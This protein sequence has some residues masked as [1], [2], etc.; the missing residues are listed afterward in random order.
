M[1]YQAEE[2]ALTEPV[3]SNMNR[4]ITAFA[5]DSIGLIPNADPVVP[6]EVE[7]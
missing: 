7:T 6:A 2:F 1:M 5:M 3:L 4:L